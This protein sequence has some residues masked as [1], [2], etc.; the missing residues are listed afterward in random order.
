MTKKKK[1][2]EESLIN[3]DE[4]G[5]KED[6]LKDLISMNEKGNLHVLR[7]RTKAINSA[8]EQIEDGLFDIL[9]EIDDLIDDYRDGKV[10]NRDSSDAVEKLFL[11]SEFTKGMEREF[12]K[13]KKFASE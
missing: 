10:F 2:E 4:F 6:E 8:L 13:M 9:F 3:L 12:A 11:L 7:H 1:T 5:I